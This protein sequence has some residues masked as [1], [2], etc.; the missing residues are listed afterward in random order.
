MSYVQPCA[1]PRASSLNSSICALIPVLLFYAESMSHQTL[2]TYKLSAYSYQPIR[3]NIHITVFGAFIVSLHACLLLAPEASPQPQ[4]LRTASIACTPCKAHAFRVN[5][6]A[7][8]FPQSTST[9]QV[10]DKK[11]GRSRQDMEA[12]I[13]ACYFFLYF[14]VL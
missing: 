2:L 6:S 3:L 12:R 10:G 1:H 8:V 13:V 9:R 11:R 14:T 4:A 7:A 5:T